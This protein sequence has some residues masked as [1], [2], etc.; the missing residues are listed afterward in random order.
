[1]ELSSEHIEDFDLPSRR[2]S[3]ELQKMNDC[4][5][6]IL[7]MSLSGI[8]KQKEIAEIL[9]ISKVMVRYTMQSAVFKNQQRVMRAVMDAEALDTAELIQRMAP[10]A[11][12]K[13]GGLLVNSNDDK[14]I[15]ATAKDILDRAGYAPTKKVDVR[16]EGTLTMTDIEDIKAEAAKRALS[17]GN[18]VEEVEFEEIDE[19]KEEEP[20]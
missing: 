12:Q 18:L 19:K 17:A 8:Y 16:L 5:L 6:A 14:V 20:K 4:H 2:G 10:L 3:Y 1:M 9:E 11:I 13:L 7:R 15:R